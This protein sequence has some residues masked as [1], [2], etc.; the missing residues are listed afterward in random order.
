MGKKYQNG[1]KLADEVSIQDEIDEASEQ[2]AKEIDVNIDEVYKTSNKMLL[3]E[4]NSLENGE[5]R[6]RAI[7]DLEVME[8]INAERRKRELDEEKAQLEKDKAED[9]YGLRQQELALQKEQVKNSK[10]GTWVSALVSIGTTALSFLAYG[11]L[12][13]RQNEFER[14][15][16][17][18]TS[19][20]RGLTQNISR[21]PKIR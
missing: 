18:S 8:R 16:N 9:E 2:L 11:F 13:N 21:L 12:L 17:Y 1:T 14:D 20:S 3:D 10:R 5:E 6:S 7:R 15:D 19:G 4:I